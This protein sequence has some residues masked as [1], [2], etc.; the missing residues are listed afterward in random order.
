LC[1]YISILEYHFQIIN[2]HRDVTKK[3]QAASDKA[4]DKAVTI[5]VDI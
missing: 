1:I 5:V 4:G 2:P 3:K